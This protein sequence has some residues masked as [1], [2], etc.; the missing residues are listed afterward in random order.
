MNWKDNLLVIALLFLFSTYGMAQ[1]EEGFEEEIEEEMEEEN[2]TGIRF[3]F[4]GNFRL[5]FPLGNFRNNLN[6]VGVGAGGSFLMRVKPD[7]PIFAGVSLG[8]ITYDS[9]RADLILFDDGISYDA[10]L[11]TRTSIFM[12]HGLLRFMPPVN[13]S[14]KPYFEG[15]VGFKN[16][17]TRTTLKDEE[18]IEDDTIST[19][20]DDG[21]WAFSFGGAIGLHIPV[22]FS[23]EGIF[24]IDIQCAY[25]MGNAADYNVRRADLDN[26]TI[27]DTI[28]AFELKNSTTDMLMP[29][30]G[31]SVVF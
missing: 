21:D 23:E 15:R 1:V 14:L 4:D 6:R 2:V 10:S 5:G 7:L 11:V 30:I 31:F 27:E 18:A 3:I 19:E 29:T 8:W 16:L 13:F 25:L 12:G 20:I 17:Y 22:S 9:E 26:T 28:E 24:S